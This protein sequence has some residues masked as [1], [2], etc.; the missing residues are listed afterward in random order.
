MANNERLTKR[1]KKMEDWIAENGSGPTL[2][3][4]NYLLDM[5][6]N[7][8]QQF[9]QMEGQH[10]QYRA[11]VEEFFTTEDIGDKWN[12]FIKEK[13]DA[14][15]KQQAEEVSVQEEAEGSEEVVEAQEEE[16]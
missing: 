7:A 10:N 5:L 2:D 14:V 12:E 6:K 4:F 1:V 16:E 15:Q 11:L 9:M 3:N 8:S 13:D